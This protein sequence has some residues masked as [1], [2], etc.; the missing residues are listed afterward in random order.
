MPVGT[1]RLHAICPRCHSR[2]RHRL[3]FLVMSALAN[4]YDFSSLQ[5]LHMAPEPAMSDIFRR[6]FSSYMTADITGVRVDRR[7]DLTA[8]DLP[9]DSALMLSTRHMF[10]NTLPMTARL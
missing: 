8:M 1:N 9:D 7:L 5:F 4:D 10:S 6:Q 2:E 3:Q